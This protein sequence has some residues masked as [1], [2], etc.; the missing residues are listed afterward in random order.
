MM[1]ATGIKCYFD[2]ININGVWKKDYSPVQKDL[3]KQ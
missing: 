2:S 3:I 1:N